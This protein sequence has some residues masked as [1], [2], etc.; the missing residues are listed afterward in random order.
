M[1]TALVKTTSKSNHVVVRTDGIRCEVELD[2]RVIGQCGHPVRVRVRGAGMMWVLQT[3]PPVALTD[4]ERDTIEAAM[5]AAYA[6][7]PRSLA[8]QRA[9]LVAAVTAAWRRWEDARE[10]AFA[11]DHGQLPTLA[12]V[13][14]ARAA[15]AAFD[16]AHPEIAAAIKA[17][18]DAETAANIRAA[19][20]A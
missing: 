5:N 2:G 14:A 19:E 6:A 16:A 11:A 3:T 10:A 9:E 18:H 15:L 13:E 7:R 12:E 8:E 20:N 1:Q 4:A 17:A